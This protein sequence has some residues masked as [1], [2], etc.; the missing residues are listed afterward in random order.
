MAGEEPAGE[1]VV[2][3]DAR[4]VP[5]GA[6]LQ[7]ENPTAITVAAV[8]PAAINGFTLLAQIGRAHV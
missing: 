4:P 2:I 7:P 8:N 5:A 1:V 6:P 3:V